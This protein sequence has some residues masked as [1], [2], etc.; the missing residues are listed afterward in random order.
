MTRQPDCLEQSTG[1]VLTTD[2]MH[3]LNT[4]AVYGRQLVLL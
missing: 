2:F 1:D 4:L 3:S